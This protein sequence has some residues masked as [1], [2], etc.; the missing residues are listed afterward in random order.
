MAV[1]VVVTMVTVLGMLFLLVVVSDIFNYDHREAKTDDFLQFPNMTMTS[2]SM[3]CWARFEA[4]VVGSLQIQLSIE[5]DAG[6][7]AYNAPLIII[8]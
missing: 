1:L 3:I 4:N 6:V 8:L 2:I 7:G 5:L